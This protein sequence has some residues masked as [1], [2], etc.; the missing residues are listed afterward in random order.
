[1]GFRRELQCAGVAPIFRGGLENATEWNKPVCFV[2]LDFARAYDSVKRLPVARSM[3]KR[4]VQAPI[5]AAYL[6]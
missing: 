3:S 1:M 2:R 5:A 6:R 4:R